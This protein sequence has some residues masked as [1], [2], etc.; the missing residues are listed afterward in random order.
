MSTNIFEPGFDEPTDRPGF[1]YRRARI[2]WQAGSARLGASLYEVEPGNA[3]FPYH[4]HSNNEELLIVL[5]GRP[6]LRTPGGERE[7]A[8]GEVVAFPI[9]EDG[10]HQ[11]VNQSEETVRFLIVSEMNDVDLNGYPDSGKIV[12]TN[13]APGARPKPGSKFFSFRESD[14]VDY[15]DGE[16][17]PA[18][19]EGA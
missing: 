17:N 13:R 18:E 7:L 14:A 2:G 6:R 8:P 10:A 12:A 1:T 3:C 5:S 15:M 9:G 19:R 4:W 16:P 11:V